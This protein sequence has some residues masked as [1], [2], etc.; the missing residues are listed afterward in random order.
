MR[1]EERRG[2]RRVGLEGVTLCQQALQFNHRQICIKVQRRVMNRFF[3]CSLS[4]SH[5][6]FL[7][8]FFSRSLTL[9]YYQCQN[10]VFFMVSFASFVFMYV[11]MYIEYVNY[12]CNLT[13]F[14]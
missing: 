13:F 9:F 12:G 1:V 2:E 14:H 10:S 8:L 6:L 11:C 3:L 4:L 5:T 7:S